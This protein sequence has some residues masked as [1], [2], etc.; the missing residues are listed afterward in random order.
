MSIEQAGQST[1]APTERTRTAREFLEDDLEPADHPDVVDCQGDVW[2]WHAGYWH[3]RSDRLPWNSLVA[4]WGPLTEVLPAYQWLLSGENTTPA[5]KDTGEDSSEAQRLAELIDPQAWSVEPDE[6]DTVGGRWRVTEGR[7]ESLEAA[8]RILAAGW[9]PPL[10][11]SETEWGIRGR[12]QAAVEETG[13]EGWARAVAA[14]HGLEY[15]LVQRR[16]P[17]PWI[18]VTS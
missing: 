12:G 6:V 10:P 16:A 18:E 1:P 2:E 15:E 11:D 7:R 8:Q 17:G 3:Y 14:R 9:W 13:T 4:A 5:G